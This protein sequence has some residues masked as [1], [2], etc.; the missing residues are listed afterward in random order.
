M[1]FRVWGRK[2]LNIS[3]LFGGGGGCLLLSD[4]IDLDYRCA[5][6][7][8]LISSVAQRVRNDSPFSIL[9][10]LLPVLL[11]SIGSDY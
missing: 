7:R 8:T 3:Y 4:V 2:D 11:V 10:M 5:K 6:Y 1:V 9:V